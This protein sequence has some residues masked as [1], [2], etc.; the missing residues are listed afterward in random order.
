MKVLEVGMI[1]RRHQDHLRERSVIDS[2]AKRATAPAVSLPIDYPDLS[3]PDESTNDE[4]N[5]ENVTEGTRSV[6]HPPPCR[7]PK[8]N[9]K[10]PERYVP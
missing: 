3:V 7:N 6:E 2:E 8:H 5:G 1:W 9:R 10:Q 4:S